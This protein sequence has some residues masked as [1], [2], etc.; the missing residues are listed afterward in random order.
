MDLADSYCADAHKWLLTAFDASMLW[1]RHG[2]A[3]PDALGITP[4]YLR[5]AATDSGAVVDYRDWHVPLGRRF[6]ALKLWAVLRGLG[7]DGLR[8][9]V[10]SHVAW[11]GELAERVRDD[12]GFALAAEPSL[13]LVCLRVRTGRG[14]DA[15]DA[16]TAALVERVNAS[17]AALVTG[18]VVG[19]RRVLR[20]AVGSVGTEHRHVVALWELLRRHADEL[21]AA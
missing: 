4:P 7:L 15:D 20:V 13:A 9:H 21:R 2:R 1:T 14:D 18:T 8:R 12:P 19:G 6:R 3:L 17:G 10:R 5:D 11:A 16:A